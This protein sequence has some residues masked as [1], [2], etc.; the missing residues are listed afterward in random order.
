MRRLSLSYFSQE[1]LVTWRS[2][3]TPSLDCFHGGREPWAPRPHVRFS[4]ERPCRKQPFFTN[5]SLPKPC[6]CICFL[7]AFC[8]W[9]TQ[10][11]HFKFISQMGADLEVGR[12][13]L[14]RGAQWL[15]CISAACIVESAVLSQNGSEKTSGWRRATTLQKGNASYLS[16]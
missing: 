15:T 11:Q 16:H 2:S 5:L 10:C 14:L 4:S 13:S 1:L 3:A 9:N 8:A 7:D 6:V 12:R